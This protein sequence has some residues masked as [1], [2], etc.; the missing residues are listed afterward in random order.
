MLRGRYGNDNLNRTLMVAAFIFS[1]LS[2]LF[3]ENFMGNAFFVVG[4]ALI[5][6]AFFRMFSKNTFRRQQENTA[7]LNIVYNVKNRF[8]NIKSQASTKYQNKVRYKVLSCPFCMQKLR[9]PRGKG[10]IRVSCTKCGQKFES[11]S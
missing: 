10:K 3:R 8:R 7:Y 6:V 9:V 1:L 5:A 2:M 11:K 4:T